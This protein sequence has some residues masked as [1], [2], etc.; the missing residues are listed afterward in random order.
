MSLLQI[1]E[2]AYRYRFTVAQVTRRLA[3][4]EAYAA[5]GRA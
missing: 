5:K 3:V 4:I 2:I 1:E